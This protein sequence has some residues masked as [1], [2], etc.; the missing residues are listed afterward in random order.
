MHENPVAFFLVSDRFKSQKMCIKALE[1]DPWQLND[2][3]DLKT[4]KMCDKTVMIP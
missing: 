3:P 1:V 4:T 2:I